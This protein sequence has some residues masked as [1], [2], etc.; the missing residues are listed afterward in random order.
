VWAGQADP[1]AVAE[2]LK[3]QSADGG[4]SN[5]ALG[6]WMAHADAPVVAGSNGYATAF[7]TFVLL[8]SGV[9]ASDARIA[10]ALAWLK[11]HQDPSTGAW[12]AV[13]MN[14]QRPAGSME[15]QFMQDAATAFASLA[16]LDAGQ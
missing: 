10:R 3:R 16:L 12:P 13:S 9:P 15:A 5:E 1:A 14:K 7:T 2:T 4:W 6:P 8:K 11:A